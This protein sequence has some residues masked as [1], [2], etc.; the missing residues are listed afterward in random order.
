[1]SRDF[2]SKANI[3]DSVKRYGLPIWQSP[4]FLFLIMGVVTITTTII[5]YTIGSR[6]IDDPSTVTLVVFS[7]TIILFVFSFIITKS[8][9]KLVDAA[10]MKTEFISVVSHQLRSPLTNL[11]WIIEVFASGGLGQID[12]KQTKYLTILKE[13]S[14]RMTDL[15]NDLITVSRIETKTFLPQKT[16]F[17]FPGLIKMVISEFKS[18]YESRN[19]EIKFQTQ[20]NLQK[21]S[22][23]HDLLKM[24]IVNLLDNAI[25]YTRGRGI[26]E[27][28]LE[29][30]R[31]KFYFEIKD[32]GVGIPREDQKY[33]FQKFFRS[34]NILR[35]QTRGIGLGLYI[36][37]SI[38][39][40]L[41]GTI[42]FKSQEGVGSAFWFTL[43]IK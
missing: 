23:S 11:K 18:F 19:I 32:S 31:K 21:I 38:I 40:K 34:S 33:I 8:F 36:V 37:K 25:R 3:F 9:E 42:W 1:M 39:E 15:I 12:E 16:E 30:R 20:E 29:K 10:R 24:V 28:G 13:N 2:F 41:G 7:L 4:Q 14:D 43:P 26:I 6:Y 22:V 17:S 27:I 5:T 35:Y